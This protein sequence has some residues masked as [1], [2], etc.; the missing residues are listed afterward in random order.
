VAAGKA[1]ATT[2]GHADPTNGWAR[3]FPADPGPAEGVVNSVEEARAA[4]RQRYK[5]GS[6]T[7]KITATGGVLSI[8]KSGSNPQFTE[9]EIRAI[10]STARDYGFKVAAHAHGAEGI[11]RAVRG[12]VDTIEHGTFLDDEGIR[13]MVA[14]GTYLVPTIY[15]GDYYTEGDKLRAQDKQ[16]DYTANQRGKFLAAV[17]RAHK[18][19]VKIAVGVDLGG[20]MTDPKVFVREM[21]V[22]VEA[23]FTP[24]EAIQAGTR[25]GAE[26]LRWDDRL[27]TV[28]AG[29]LADLVAVS[30]N[31]LEDM[32]A[33][34]SVSF[35]MVNGRVAKKPGDMAGLGGTLTN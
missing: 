3:K 18:Q 23:G 11:K 33:L 16:D 31:P 9:E 34:E 8:A 15:V 6:D 12:G 25:V 27:G 1:I 20:Y 21:A 32:K 35:V 29:K 19:G 30:G 2:G 14:K 22:L 4:V 17:G 24:M 13:M 7:I 5:D 10:V 26:L 28:Q